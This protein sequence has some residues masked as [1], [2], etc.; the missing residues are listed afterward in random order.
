MAVILNRDYCRNGHER[1][2]VGATKSGNCRPCNQVYMRL[3][4]QTAAY[5]KYISSYNK[6][7]RS[8]EW[9][10]NYQKSAVVK[11][12]QK[13]YRQENP[14]LYR[15]LHSVCKAKRK[16]RIAK[17]GQEGIRRF[18]KNTPKGMVVDHIIPLQGRLVSGLHVVWNLQYLTPEEN[19]R[20]GN[21]YYDK[22]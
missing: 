10:K 2:V 8:S 17:F 4:K 5:K 1:Q 16:F 14:E 22:Q 19:M 6:K 3:Y 11:D 13:R 20:K 9:Y 18:Y 15:M 12:I 7:F 21:K